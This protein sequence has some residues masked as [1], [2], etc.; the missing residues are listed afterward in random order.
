MW[1]NRWKEISYQVQKCPEEPI[2][3]YPEHDREH[4]Y[5]ISHI[6]ID[7]KPNASIGSLDIL[8][9]FTGKMRSTLDA[10]LERSNLRCGYS[11]PFYHFA[12]CPHHLQQLCM[13]QVRQ[14]EAVPLW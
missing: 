3:V 14:R 11:F 9:P 2:L 12:D 13:P 8:A 10:F 6:I 1:L 7:G 5:Y 4:T